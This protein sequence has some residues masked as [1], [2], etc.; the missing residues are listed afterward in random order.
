MNPN[1]CHDIHHSLAVEYVNK[2]ISVGSCCQSG[3]FFS[4]SENTTINRLWNIDELKKIREDNLNG[5]LSDIFCNSCTKLE[6]VGNKSRRHASEEFYRGWDSSNKTIRALDIKLG[7]LCNL[8]CT[9]CGPDSSSA[10]IPDAKKLDVN[11]SENYYYNKHY[12]KNLELFVDDVSI[13]KDLEMIKFWG[14]EPLIDEKHANILDNLDQLGILKNC[15]IVYNTNGTHRVSD[16][17]LNL[18][19]KAHLVE[20]YFSI[21]DIGDRFNYQ[22]YGASWNLVVDNL[23]WYYESLPSNHLFYLMTTISYLNIWYLPELYEWKKQ[24]FDTNRMSDETRILLQPASGT[25]SVDTMSDKI[26]NRLLDKFKL[27]PDLTDFLKFPK[28]KIDHVPVKF[29]NYI[30]KLDQ[31]RNTNW[32]NTFNEFATIL[33]D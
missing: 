25:C 11:I 8:K 16:R 30:D 24:N 15:R 4:D 21:D 7:N 29:F 6:S 10:W 18:W 14:G 33:N 3:T 1:Y 31:I 22:R 9:I 26:K 12:D 23:K 20:L 27:Y 19:K 32:K 5:K 2:K 13:L 17:V 28:V